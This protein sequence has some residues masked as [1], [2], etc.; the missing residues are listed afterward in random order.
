M[1]PTP[2]CHPSFFIVGP[3]ASGAAALYYRLAHHPSVVKNKAFD[4]A[5]GGPLLRARTGDTNAFLFA[6]QSIVTSPEKTAQSIGKVN[7]FFSDGETPGA[8]T[9]MGEYGSMY[10]MHP[11]IQMTMLRTCPRSSENFRFIVT[12]RD[13]MERLQAAYLQ[14]I[15][16]EFPPAGLPVH[17]FDISF[18]SFSF[19]S[20]A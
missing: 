4:N 5:L 18:L 9:V 16:E 10:F 15:H 11:T 17:S 2:Q 8:T 12:L 19:F 7:S 20:L 14:R 3:S 6:R 1:I 13:P